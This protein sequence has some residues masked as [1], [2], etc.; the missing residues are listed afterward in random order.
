MK[1]SNKYL[2]LII[3]LGLISLGVRQNAYAQIAVRGNA[4][5]G[6]KLYDNLFLVLDIAPPE[7]DH[8]LW[9]TQDFNPRKGEVT[10]GCQ[11]CHGWD[12]K[13][14]GG[15][16]GIGSS[17]Y[18]GFPG[19]T[20]SIGKSQDEVADWLNGTNNPDHDFDQFMGSADLDDLIAFVRTKQVDMALLVDYETRTILGNA[21]WGRE[22]YEDVCAACH[23]LD[24]Q[25]V[26]LEYPTGETETRTF[27]LNDPWR[28]I[29]RTRFGTPLSGMPS[30]ESLGWTLQDIADVLAYM[31]S[32]FPPE[33]VLTIPG[34]VHEFVDTEGQGD[35]LIITWG[36]LVIV[37]VIF[38]S[39]AWN[40]SRNR[41]NHAHH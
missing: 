12:Y 9:V 8:P 34:E 20:G 16:Y 19:M 21:G 30:Y 18:T 13:G 24:G 37:L 39:L 7:G 14:E 25:T 33:Q 28:A 10:W 31:Q 2:L 29:H 36:A 41:A 4:L 26:I 11:T 5:R 38:G 22:L 1:T 27:L 35:T 17:A 3:I 40:N 15:Q 23:S 6:A 32:L